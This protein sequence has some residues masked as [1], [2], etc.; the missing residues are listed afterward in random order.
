MLKMEFKGISMPMMVILLIT[1]LHSLTTIV[2][3]AAS[4]LVTTTPRNVS[5]DV[6]G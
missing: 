2:S 1:G 4:T 3:G 6:M 5:I